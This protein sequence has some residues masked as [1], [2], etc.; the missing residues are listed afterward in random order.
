MSCSGEL[1]EHLRNLKPAGSDGFEGLIVKS[2][3]RLTG[4]RFFL[5]RSGDQGGR[6][7]STAGYGDT[8]IAVE[9]KMY[10]DNTSLKQDELIGKMFTA[11]RT[12]P[13]LDSWVLVATR[14][15]PDQLANALAE[16]ARTCGMA[17]E[18]ISHGN[19]S[20]SDIEVLCCTDELQAIKILSQSNPDT[21]E[22][23][24]N[25]SIQRIRDDTQFV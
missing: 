5:A 16:G 25:A 1:I 11:K 24:L 15:I 13:Q 18:F 17:V 20:P 22:E 4:R 8:L 21:E 7:A 6:D 19:S 10:S 3:E 14:D 12:C 9:M 2:L 23:R